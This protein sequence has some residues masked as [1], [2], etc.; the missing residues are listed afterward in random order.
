MVRVVQVIEPLFAMRA[1]QSVT[2]HNSVSGH[3]LKIDSRPIN[4]YLTAL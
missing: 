2:T 4:Y 3:A 1:S